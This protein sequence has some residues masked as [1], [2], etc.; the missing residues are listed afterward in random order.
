[1]S[2]EEYYFWIDTQGWEDAGG[3]K[4][5][6]IFKNIFAFLKKEN[7]AEI[8]GIIWNVNS[9]ERASATLQRQAALIQQFSND[10]SNIW[11]RVLIVCK[12]MHEK[13]LPLQGAREAAL[14]AQ[15]AEVSEGKLR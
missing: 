13:D 10:E 7:M 1:M 8:Q 11:E 3:E 6:Y 12:K 9:N 4:D 2:E 15:N 14:R 5:Y